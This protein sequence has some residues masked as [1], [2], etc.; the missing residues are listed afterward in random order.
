[1][2]AKGSA[3]RTRADHDAGVE[4][5]VLDN[6]LTVVS[7]QVPGV[8]SVALGAWVRTASVHETPEEM[9]V[10]HLL[11]HLCFK[12]TA[13]RTPREIAAALE[14]LG[15]S[16]DAYTAR[17]HTAFH[18]RV[19]DEH[20]PQ[21]VDVIADVMF[22][23]ALRAEDLQLE[24]KVVL[25]EIA[26]VED[27]PDD[28]VFELHSAAMWGDHPMGY[29]ILGTRASVSSM[30]I[31]QVRAL[32]ARAF[33]P[34]NVVVAAAGSV[35]HEGLVGALR[36][37]GWSDLPARPAPSHNG[38]APGGHTPGVRH[39]A[40]DCAQ[41]HLVFGSPTVPHGDPQRHALIL[42]DTLLGGG[43]SSRLFQRVREELALAYS[44]YTFQQFHRTTGLHGIY[45]GTAP[46]SAALTV[47]AIREELLRLTRDGLGEDE[48]ALGKQQLKGQVTLSMESVHSRMYR[49]AAVD[50]FDEPWRPLDAIL[51]EI[52]AVTVDQARAVCEAYFH[53][54]RQAVVHLGPA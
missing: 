35:T 5:T 16:L 6:G 40:R 8:R 23:P 18:A 45:A 30:S 54:D 12:G 15:G 47:E 11:E 42:V 2:T 34:A 13:R 36:N 3:P 24:K 43:M 50:L 1:M 10:S 19:L 27:T 52:D 33:V 44:V 28:V 25:E 38:A 14:S 9:G 32:H 20:L 31:E 48:I 53:P 49:A 22:H 17:E 37:A 26:M 7:E 41:A 51:A 21:A 46:E 29:S 4:R 39:V